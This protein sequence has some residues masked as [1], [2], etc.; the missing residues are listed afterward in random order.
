[1]SQRNEAANARPEIVRGIFARLTYREVEAI[2]RRSRW[3]V[4]RMWK[5]G[6]FPPPIGSTFRAD[7]VRQWQEGKTDWTSELERLRRPQN[8]EERGRLRRRGRVGGGR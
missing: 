5:A 1:M 7:W 3:T 2:T 6:L 8:G 4:R